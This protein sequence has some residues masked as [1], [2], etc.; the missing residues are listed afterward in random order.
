MKCPKEQTNDQFGLS[1]QIRTVYRYVHFLFNPLNATLNPIFHL[2]TLL[3][4]RHILHIS[5]IRINMASNSRSLSWKVSSY[6][7]FLT[8]FWDQFD[9]NSFIVSSALWKGARIS[10]DM[11]WRQWPLSVLTVANLTNVLRLSYRWNQ[12]LRSRNFLGVQE[13]E[14]SKIIDVQILVV[15]SWLNKQKVWFLW[16]QNLKQH[17]KKQRTNFRNLLLEESRRECN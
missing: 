1:H 17:R 5:R 14:R 16:D 4:A 3:G 13:F 15:R 2:L 6:S 12:T 9:K 7:Y 11:C 8:C 10:L